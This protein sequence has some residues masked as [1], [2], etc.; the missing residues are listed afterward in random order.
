MKEITRKIVLTVRAAGK[1]YRDKS[2]A[3]THVIAAMLSLF[4]LVGGSYAKYENASAI[5]GSA[6]NVAESCIFFVICFF[7][8][9]MALTWLYSCSFLKLRAFAGRLKLPAAIA[10]YPYVWAFAAIAIC[11]LPY[12]VIYF[13]GSVTHDGLRQINMSFGIEHITNHHPWLVTYIY[14]F[15]MR[16]GRFVFHNDNAAVACCVIPLG[17]F[18]LMCYAYASVSIRRWTRSDAAYVASVIFWGL[19]PVFGAY[20]QAVIKDNLFGAEAA[21]FVTLYVDSLIHAMTCGRYD[22]RRLTALMLTGLSLCMTRNNGI[23]LVVPAIAGMLFI[24]KAGR[25]VVTVLLVAMIAIYEVVQMVVPSAL[26][27]TPGSK[28]EALSIPFQQTARYVKEYPDDVTA[29]EAEV[30]GKILKY[31]DLA[32]LYTAQCSDPVKNSFVQTSTNEELK[33]YFRVWLGML[34]K[35]PGTYI[36]ATLGNAFGY[37]YP[38]YNYTGMSAY[39][40]YMKKGVWPDTGY[41]DFDYVVADTP[42][43]GLL[44][45]ANRWRTVPLLSATVNAGAYTWLIIILTGFLLYK[46]KL[47]GALAYLFA[48]FNIL[49]C[50]A[51][52]VNGYIRYALP[53][54]SAAPVFICWAWWYSTYRGDERT[55]EK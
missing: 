10:R 3:V 12:F 36:S 41:F 26:G 30:I 14:G 27:I 42:R 34:K 17:L 31:D 16:V 18:Q 1:L 51:S 54:A 19:V 46:R 15:L 29:H 39:P 37:I 35:H 5:T 45:Y 40:L 4:V 55:N 8:F 47:R 50:I 11:W 25:V 13:P 44:D 38:F 9:D 53:I 24:A 2:N 49:V 7:A 23:Y 33:D 52:P 6:A 20:A 21:L 28:K 48:I 43:R 22:R 32:Q